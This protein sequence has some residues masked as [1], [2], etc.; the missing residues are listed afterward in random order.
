MKGP[1]R[2]DNHAPVGIMGG[3]GHTPGEV[4][5]SYRRME[6]EMDANNMNDDESARDAEVTAQPNPLSAVARQPST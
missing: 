5:I 6:K 1:P 2:A 3:H 4:M